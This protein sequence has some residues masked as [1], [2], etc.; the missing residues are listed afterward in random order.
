MKP[1]VLTPLFE[2]VNYIAMETDVPLHF[3]VDTVINDIGNRIK[4]SC[5]FENTI[6]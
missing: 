6:S 2:I 1:N 4:Y 3:E 5:E